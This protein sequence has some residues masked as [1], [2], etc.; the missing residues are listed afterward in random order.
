MC[1]NLSHSV[2][3]PA[4]TVRETGNS[5][6]TGALFG[7][8]LSPVFTLKARFS[9][10]SQSWHGICYVTCTTKITNRS[11]PIKTRRIGS[12]ITRTIRTETQ[13]TDFFGVDRFVKAQASQPDREQ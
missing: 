5:E 8:E 11:N 4:I 13:L 2:T 7:F 10:L 1:D 6:T 9:G 12:V 3:L